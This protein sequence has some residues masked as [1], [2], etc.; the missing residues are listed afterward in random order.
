MEEKEFHKI[1]SDQQLVTAL[2]LMARA[3]DALVDLYIRYLSRDLAYIDDLPVDIL[4]G[5]EA[6]L[7]RELDPRGNRQ[8]RPDR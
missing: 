2:L 4:A 1:F 6:G 7:I 8:Y 3:Q 5:A